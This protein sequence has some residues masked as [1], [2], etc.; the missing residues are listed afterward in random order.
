MVFSAFWFQVSA[1]DLILSP[2]TSAIT[3]VCIY[4]L[5]GVAMPSEWWH[6]CLPLWIVPYSR[7]SWWTLTSKLASLNINSM[8]TRQ[9]IVHV[10]GCWTEEFNDAGYFR[11]KTLK[12]FNILYKHQLTNATCVVQSCISVIYS[13]TVIWPEG[14]CVTAVTRWLICLVFCPHPC[15]TASVEALLLLADNSRYF[16][17]VSWMS[18]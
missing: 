3:I 13:R 12:D 15:E 10:Q 18:I 1:F 7:V 17:E 5:Y 16:T 14:V 11:Q 4:S 8:L 9:E 2:W 6:I